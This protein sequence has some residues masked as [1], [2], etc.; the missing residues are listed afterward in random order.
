MKQKQF[1]N[2][3]EC[4]SGYRSAIMG[5]ASILVMLVHQYAVHSSEILGFFSRTG[6]WGVDIFLFVSGFGITH[7]LLKNTTKTFYV[8]RVKKMLPI[9]LVIGMFGFVMSIVHHEVDWVNLVPKL[10]CL[11]NWYVYTITIYYFFLLS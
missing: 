10:L 9:C 3:N 7:S 8:N 6:H 5:V 2:V 11:D 4:V 1:S